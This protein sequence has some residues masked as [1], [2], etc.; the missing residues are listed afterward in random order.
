M[1]F[2]ASTVLFPI[3]LS[4][5]F[6]GVFSNLRSEPK[7]EIH[8]GPSISLPSNSPDFVTREVVVSDVPELGCPSGFDLDDTQTKCIKRDKQP[9]QLGCL[10]GWTFKDGACFST[11]SVQPHFSCP[12]DYFTEASHCLKTISAPKQVTCPRGFDFVRDSCTKTVQTSPDFICSPGLD[13]KP[14]QNVCQRNEVAEPRLSCQK[15]FRLFQDMCR[16]DVSFPKGPGGCEAPFMPS[17]DG[18]CKKVE[19]IAADLVCPSQTTL[20]YD[21]SL[22]YDR[23]LCEGVIEED[24]VERCP[25]EFH[26][27]FDAKKGSN[28]CHG[29]SSA[30]P[31]VECPPGFD[32]SNS[33]C[34]KTDKIPKTAVCPESGYEYVNGQCVLPV[35]ERPVILCPIGYTLTED[36]F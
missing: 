1:E 18:T 23:E 21:T 17:V 34:T 8:S 3:L 32:V 12:S 2:S 24:V 13:Y 33:L 10:S 36:M 19:I 22:G 15:G 28:Q 16:Q 27:F 25:P 35:T 31:H 6:H 30:A 26:S 5:Y 4:T 14:S 29:K 11:L 9:S 7:F 20:R